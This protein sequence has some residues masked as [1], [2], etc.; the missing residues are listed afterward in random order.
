MGVIDHGLRSLVIF[1]LVGASSASAQ[2]LSQGNKLLGTLG[3]QAGSQVPPGLYLGD[4]ALF[5][6][7]NELKDRNGDPLDV[8]LDLDAFANGF[9]PR[10]QLLVPLDD[11]YTSPSVDLTSIT[12]S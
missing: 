7:A 2:Q 8:G 3:L 1:L 12:S 10:R 9:G 11:N 6:F 5:Y 4:R